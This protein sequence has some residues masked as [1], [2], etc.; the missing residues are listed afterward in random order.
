M[1]TTK[2]VTIA[3]TGIALAVFSFLSHELRANNGPVTVTPMIAQSAPS[4][5]PSPASANW[6][7]PHA[8]QLQITPMGQPDPI[9]VYPLGTV[10][11]KLREQY[12]TEYGEIR[13]RL[14]KEGANPRAIEE[15][16][17]D[18]DLILLDVLQGKRTHPDEI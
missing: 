1:K 11:Q 13:K 7:C 2:K 4:P 14:T 5:A 12:A 8:S 9:C 6:N 18:H 17:V 16:L 15:A 3:L 10:G